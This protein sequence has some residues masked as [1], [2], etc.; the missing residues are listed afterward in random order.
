MQLAFFPQLSNADFGAL[1]D[2]NPWPYLLSARIL[3]AL[4]GALTIPIVFLLAR[5]FR[6]HRLGIIAAAMMAVLFSTSAIHISAF[7]TR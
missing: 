3:S 4:L 7:R 6:D 5:R 1:R 2:T